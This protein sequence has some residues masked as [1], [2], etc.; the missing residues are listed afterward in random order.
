MDDS[1]VIFGRA[2]AGGNLWI[3]VPGLDTVCLRKRSQS[4]KRLSS[5]C[6][7]SHVLSQLHKEGCTY[8]PMSNIDIGHNPKTF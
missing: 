6:F 3:R 4:K 8:V 7:A 5:H 2:D 1:E